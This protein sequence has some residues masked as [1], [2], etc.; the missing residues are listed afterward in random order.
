MTRLLVRLMPEGFE[1]T[2]IAAKFD[3]AAGEVDA[4]QLTKDLVAAGMHVAEVLTKD[5]AE[6][7]AKDVAEKINSKAGLY[8]AEGPPASMLG[9]FT[10]LASVQTLLVTADP[11]YPQSDV[12]VTAQGLVGVSQSFPPHPSIF[13]HVMLA[14]VGWHIQWHISH[15]RAHVHA[16]ARARPRAHS[17]PA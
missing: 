6:R 2:K 12:Q 1:W 11:P 9:R 4:E 10:K 16:C 14:H 17:L 5:V 3:P 15:S 13:A 7:F 8:T